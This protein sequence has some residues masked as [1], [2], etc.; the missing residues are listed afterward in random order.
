[1][2]GWEEQKELRVFCVL[3]NQG[4]L[5]EQDSERCECR[6]SLE[7]TWERLTGALVRVQWSHAET[8]GEEEGGDR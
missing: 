4:L 6:R 7:G 5:F 3:G 2:P 8:Q 1:M